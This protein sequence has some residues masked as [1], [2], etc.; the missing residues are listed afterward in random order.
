MKPLT[1]AAL[2]ACA[3]LLAATPSR[4]DGS[5]TQSNPAARS[6]TQPRAGFGN[7]GWDRRAYSRY[8]RGRERDRCW[9]DVFRQ[10]HCD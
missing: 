1:I 2:A 4:A 8:E 7:R 10:K 6:E 3:T 9:R 5:D